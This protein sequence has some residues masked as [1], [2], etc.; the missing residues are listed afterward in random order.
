MTKIGWMFLIG[1][2]FNLVLG[3]F[4]IYGQS[5][6]VEIKGTATFTNLSTGR[7]F[8]IAKPIVIDLDKGEFFDPENPE[9]WIES[10]H[11]IEIKTEMVGK[12]DRSGWSPQEIRDYLSLGYTL[13]EDGS[14]EKPSIVG[15][16]T[17]TFPRY[18]RKYGGYI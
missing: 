18:S 11:L 4:V 14:L 1:I 9:R 5:D 3:G 13:N 10:G 6:Q 8:I 17:H 16:R 2:I 7:S 12:H 15:L